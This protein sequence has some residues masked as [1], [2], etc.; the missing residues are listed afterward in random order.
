V[1]AILVRAESERPK[2]IV[3]CCGQI[4]LLRKIGDEIC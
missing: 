2:L 4:A 3:I 1:C